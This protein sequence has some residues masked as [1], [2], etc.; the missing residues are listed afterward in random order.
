MAYSPNSEGIVF[1]PKIIRRPEKIAFR[2]GVVHEGGILY[3][4]VQKVG[5]IV[6]GNGEFQI[7][8]GTNASSLISAAKSFAEQVT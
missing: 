2:L 1:R 4:G 3:T 8:P 6:N 5:K 7:F